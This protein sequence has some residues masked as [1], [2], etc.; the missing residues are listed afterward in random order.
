MMALDTIKPCESAAGQK[1]IITE[2]CLNSELMS[3]APREKSAATC[4]SPSP[5]AWPGSFSFSIS[6]SSTSAPITVS[7]LVFSKQ[8]EVPAPSR[9]MVH[10]S[11]QTNSRAGSGCW[12]ASAALMAH[13]PPIRSPDVKLKNKFL[14][15]TAEQVRSRLTQPV[16]CTASKQV[17]EQRA[18]KMASL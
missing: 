4:P 18:W 9:Y 15:R 16:P 7:V 11:R 10:S 1:A 17:F 12:L 3:S 13:V 2:R 8:G 5:W 14:M 6:R